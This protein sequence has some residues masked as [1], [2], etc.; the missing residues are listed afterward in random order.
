VSTESGSWRGKNALKFNVNGLSLRLLRNEATR[1]CTLQYVAYVAIIP[2]ID[3]RPCT[4][5]ALLVSP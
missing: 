3:P 4:A 2:E 5:Q 1:L